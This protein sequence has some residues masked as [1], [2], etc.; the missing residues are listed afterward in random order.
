[1]SQSERPLVASRPSWVRP[2][3]LM[4]AGIVISLIA[5]RVAIAKTRAPETRVTEVRLPSSSAAQIIVYDT[6]WCGACK[7]LERALRER[8][9]PFDTI[10]V[11]QNPKAFQRA[12]EATG[13]RTVPQTEVAK[14]GASSSWIVGVNVAAIERAYRDQ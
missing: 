4:L 14:M 3:G 6:S 7:S 11:E 2:L 12:Q 13:R 5:F 9:I 10:D 8:N 1:M